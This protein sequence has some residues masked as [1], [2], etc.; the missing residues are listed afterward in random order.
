MKLT[1]RE[2]PEMFSWAVLR[3]LG[4]DERQHLD[5]VRTKFTTARL[6]TCADAIEEGVNYLRAVVA[7]QGVSDD[8]QE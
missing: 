3:R 4:L 5:A 6:A 8:T 7:V 2:R 1:E